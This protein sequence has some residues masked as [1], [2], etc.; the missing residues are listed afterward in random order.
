MI[1]AFDSGIP[2]FEI[3]APQPSSPAGRDILRL[4]VRN[5]RLCGLSTPN[6]ELETRDGLVFEARTG[7]GS[8]FTK[9]VVRLGLCGCRS[10]DT[11]QLLLCSPCDRQ[12]NGSDQTVSREIGRVPSG[13]N[14]FHDVRR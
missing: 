5:P 12:V 13:A 8:L 14:C 3:Q 2:W 10:K 9:L 4:V 11:E 7:A 6:P 1:W